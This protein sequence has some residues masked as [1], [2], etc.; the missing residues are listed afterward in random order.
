MVGDHHLETSGSVRTGAVRGALMVCGTT[1]DA[2]KSTLVAALCRILA[3]EGVRVAPFK[4][5]NMALNSAVTADGHEIGRAQAFQAFAAGVAPEV[6]MNPVLLKP[7]GDRSSQVVVWGEPR[8]VMTAAEYHR[9]K[10]DLLGL[11]LDALADLR[12]RFDVVLCEGAGSPAEINLLDHDIVNLRIAAEAGLPAIV[13]GNIDLGGV[14]AA[15]HGT[16][17]LLPPALRA[18]VR[19]FVINQLRGDPSLL[20]DGCA[21]LQQRSGV[22]VLGVVPWIDGLQVDAEDSLSLGRGWSSDEVVDGDLLDVAVVAFPHISNFTDLDPLAAE[23]SVRVRL[24]AD[25]AGF[26]RPDLVVLPGTKTTVDDL[27]WLRARGLDRSLLACDATVLGICGG[28]Q[29][30]GCEIRDGVES[31]AEVVSGLGLLPVTTEFGPE[32]V[33]RQRQG[34]ALGH[35]IAGYQIHHGR[36][37]PTGGEPFVVLDGEVE[38]VQAG[39]TFGT[40]LHGLFEAD[41]LRHA[42]L[43]EVAARAGKRL[44]PSTVRWAELR[45][46]HVDRLA[47]V[48]AEHLDLD[49]VL[50]LIR[51]ARPVPVGGAR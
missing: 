31:T 9:H 7:T 14:F 19:G 35:P 28:Y 4:A 6:A 24:V 43:T 16:V 36:V 22:P 29:A 33:L 49:A 30:L 50:Q 46:Q 1:S 5:Q 11:V 27:A 47:E 17:D 40:T 38:G 25:A 44:A 8:G 13:V 48:V 45:Q 51:G 42:F 18:Q 41:D 34:T 10:P 21:Q 23:P 20:L 15:L 26:G 2:G 37:T 12:A 3:R 32:K 39:C